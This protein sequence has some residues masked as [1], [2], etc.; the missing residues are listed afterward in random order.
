MLSISY[1]YRSAGGVYIIASTVA[2]CTLFLCASEH[3]QERYGR[4]SGRHEAAAAAAGG[5]GVSWD[6][7]VDW[8]GRLRHRLSHKLHYF[9]LLLILMHNKSYNK[10][11]I[12]ELSTGIAG[13]S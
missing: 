10:L 11:Y 9:D 12:L 2:I 6:F 1:A 5:G 4:A 13:R 8:P 7:S 3:G